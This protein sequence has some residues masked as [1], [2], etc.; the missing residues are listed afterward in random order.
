MAVCSECSQEDG[1]HDASAR[2]IRR[3]P[4]LWLLA[5]IPVVFAA[6]KLRPD[7]PTLLFAPG[8]GHRAAGRTAGHTSPSRRR[9]AM[10]SAVF[11]TPRSAI[12]PSLLLR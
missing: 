12:S 6:Q 5:F 10:R 4:L 11:L 9:Q 8:A 2:E 1:G 3:N 7:A